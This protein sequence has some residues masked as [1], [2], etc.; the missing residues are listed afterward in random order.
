MKKILLTTIILSLFSLIGNSQIEIN[1]EGQSTD[2]SGTVLQ[3]N[4]DP[5]SGNI[6]TTG[7]YL[8][9][10]EIH[11]NTGINKSWRITRKE[12]SV[13]AAWVDMLC[14]TSCFPPSTLETYCTPASV[15]L[16][17]ANGTSAIVILHFS[18]ELATAT[19]AIYR[20][21]VSTDCSTFEDSVDIQ[22]NYTAAGLKSLKN[23]ATFNI[24]PNPAND[25]TVVT[26][27]G[28]ENSNVKIVDV[29]GNVVYVETISSTKKIDLSEFKNGIYFVTIETSDAKISNRKLIVRH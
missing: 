28:V 25:Y 18:P 16:V 10:L 11:N 29:L 17:V 9:D 22:F 23:N 20:Y 12:L 26:S 4:I 27:A 6:P 1:V 19:T 8:L 3:I 13:P 14:F 2:I 7:E 5:S 21:Y 24:A 15:P